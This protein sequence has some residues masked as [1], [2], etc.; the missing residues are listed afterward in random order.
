[1]D[2]GFV[3]TQAIT[4]AIGVT[5]IIYL[6]ATMG[7][8][9][10]FGYT[11][12]LNFGQ[13]AFVAVGSYAIGVFM[14]QW[15]QNPWP[16]WMPWQ[17]LVPNLWVAILYALLLSVALSLILGIPTLRLR[18][19]YL[20]I[21]TI[22]TGEIMRLAFKSTDPLGGSQ[23]INGKMGQDFYDLNPFPQQD[24]FDF[25][26]LSYTRAD[27]W[28]V[29]VGWLVIALL[30]LLTWA[31]MRSPWGRVLKGI[32]EDEDAVRSLGKNTYLRKMQALIL[33]GL[34][35][36]LSGIFWA[37]AK[38]SV[39]PDSFVPA[40]T[41]F[42]YT[43][44]ILG[45]AARVMGPVLGAIIFWFLLV[46]IEQFLLLLIDNGTI[47]FLVPTQVGPIRF[48][49][50]GLGLMLLMIFRPQGILGDKKEIALDAR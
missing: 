32:R 48:I 21:V 17:T 43:I 24:R 14:V 47:T 44:L 41:F 9:I 46:F 34:F 31:L 35:G 16:G 36:S 23:G 11:G 2:M 20:A 15:Q 26:P 39:Q 38:Q 33:G 12:L 13:I 8:N 30:L 28:V 27:L 19:D 6:L 49:L 3:L 7:L 22:A 10:Q 1:M 45:G 18:A 50:V 42:C 4:Q 40:F 25:G 5:A 37:I 29:L